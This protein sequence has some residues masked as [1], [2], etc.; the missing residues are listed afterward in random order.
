MEPLM[1]FRAIFVLVVGLLTSVGLCLTTS[2]A[3]EGEREKR[4]EREADGPREKGN[5]RVLSIESIMKTV[6][7]K[8]GLMKSLEP[9]LTAKQVKWDQV[10]ATTAKILP[11][12]VALGKRK[13]D[14]GTKESWADL[15][16]T[17]ADFAKEL[18]DAAKKKDAVAAKDAFD[19]LNNSC[20]KCHDRHKANGR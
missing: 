4:K 11:L 15:T 17:Y 19:F 9:M 5:G 7:G 6:H 10:Q 13:P 3:D 2:S 1:R 14:K 20:S 8:R 16:D 18:D 12:A